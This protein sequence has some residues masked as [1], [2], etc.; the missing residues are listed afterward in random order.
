[1]LIVL[2][3][4]EINHRRFPSKQNKQHQCRQNHGAQGAQEDAFIHRQLRLDGLRKNRGHDPVLSRKKHRLPRTRHEQQDDKNQSQQY[5]ANHLPSLQVNKDKGS[6]SQNPDQRA[7][8][9]K[10]HYRKNRR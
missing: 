1:M 6:G 7:Q 9:W 2:F 8:R 10:N 3:L 5:Q 4:E